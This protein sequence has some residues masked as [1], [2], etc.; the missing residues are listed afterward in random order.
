MENR[1]AAQ[2]WL[3]AELEH[4]ARWAEETEELRREAAECLRRS[5]WWKKEL[6]R[7]RL[8]RD[9]NGARSEHGEPPDA[10][11]TT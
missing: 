3:A 9:R 2:D 10:R 5:M 7:Q 8:R 4:A 6:R 1:R 11:M